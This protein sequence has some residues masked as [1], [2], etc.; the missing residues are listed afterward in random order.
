[1]T[2]VAPR[3]A[4][5]KLESASIEQN[6]KVTWQPGD[7]KETKK[8][9]KKGEMSIHLAVLPE[10]KADL[11]FK[12]LPGLTEKALAQKPV[13]LTLREK[14]GQLLVESNYTGTQSVQVGEKQV[15]T[16]RVCVGYSREP[17]ALPGCWDGPVPDENPLTPD[18][19]YRPVMEP[20]YGDKEVSK[21]ET[22]AVASQEGFAD[23]A[24]LLQSVKL[25]KSV[26]KPLQGLVTRYFQQF[27]GKRESELSQQ[28]TQLQADQA[29]ALAQLDAKQQQER[30]GVQTQKTKALSEAQQRQ[31][32]LAELKKQFGAP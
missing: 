22:V 8:P 21:A 31:S 30:Q 19:E 3:F 6:K 12:T 18:Y 7:A 5:L 23:L 27:V 4:A 16:E 1:M 28:Q 17:I 20:I 25:P 15:G 13:K 14:E 11:K 32:E 26:Q 10:D 9:S 2:K 29:E 24:Q